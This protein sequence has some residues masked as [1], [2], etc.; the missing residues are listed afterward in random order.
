MSKL[1]EEDAFKV[2]AAWRDEEYRKAFVAALDK[3]AQDWADTYGNANRS[4]DQINI[5]EVSAFLDSRHVHYSEC[6]PPTH[7]HYQ[8]KVR[9]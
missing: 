6:W 5:C 2:L 4:Q 3:V 7:P 1:T 8:K 9:S